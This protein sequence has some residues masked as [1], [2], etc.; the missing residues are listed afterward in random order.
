M[1]G[2]PAELTKILSAPSTLARP[3]AEADVDVDLGCETRISMSPYEVFS[4]ASIGV[5]VWV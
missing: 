5:A 1:S 4:G 3:S 2:D